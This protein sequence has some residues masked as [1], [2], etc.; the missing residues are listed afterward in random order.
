M[1][2]VWWGTSDKGKPRNPIMLGALRATGAEV[3]E[4]HHNL[5][6][7]IKD[8]SQLGGVQRALRY[9]RWL[10]AYPVLLARFLT[11]PKPDAIMLGYPAQLDVLII[12]LVARLR[13]VPILMDLFISIYDTAVVDRRMMPPES[14][15]ARMLWALEWLGC[16]AADRV[17]IDTQAH[18][19]YVE[20]LFRLPEN[21]VGSVPVGVEEGHFQRQG[22]AQCGHRPQLLFYGQ[23]IPLHGIETVL[24]A[25]LSDR[26]KEYDWVIIG[27]GQDAA[28]VKSALGE[29]TPGHV[30]WIDWAPYD[31]LTR[32]IARS[33]ICLGI[34]GGS[35][36]AASV[37]PNKVYQALS[38]G[39]HVVTRASPAMAE[40]VPGTEPGITLVEADSS[41][42]LLDGI[43]AAARNG[44]PPPSLA[45][46]NR[47]SSKR[48]GAKLLGHFEALRREPRFQV[49]ANRPPSINSNHE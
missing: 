13:G 45:L 34:F 48:I 43:E 3:V 11:T 35:R 26:G 21:S 5:W 16:R 49:A 31:E 42:A 4:I 38:C 9:A 6:S 8:K 18:A 10:A 17:I 47:F 32:W 27:S 40:L 1:K 46:V 14:L 36:K 41:D 25:A 28:K 19:R 29:K 44:C 2:I 33:D 23:L 39:R 7:G 15:K 20:E 12:W 37:V 24:T 30:T 22:P